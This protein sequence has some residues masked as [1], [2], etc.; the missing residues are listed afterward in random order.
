MH[1][2]RRYKNPRKVNYWTLVGGGGTA[3][4]RPSLATQP[5][6]KIEGRLGVCLVYLVYLVCLVAGSANPPDGSKTG[7]LKKKAG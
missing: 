6:V 7:R 1:E 5:R 2:L 3:A 4:I